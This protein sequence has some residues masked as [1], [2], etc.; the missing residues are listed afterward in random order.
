MEF[1]SELCKAIE[2]SLPVIEE[3][4]A[5][6]SKKF[7]VTIK[8]SRP[9]KYYHLEEYKMNDAD[10]VLV[11]MG[12]VCGTIKEVIDSLRGKGVKVGL[13]KLITYR[14]FPS[15][16]LKKKLSPYKKVAVIE[17]ALSPGGRLPLYVEIAESLYEAD[18]KPQLRSFVVGLGG[19]DVTLGHIEK[20][21]NMTAKGEGKKEEWMF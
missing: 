13:L 10:V 9:E 15:E 19:R 16:L 6:F 3:V 4:M 21:I 18:K 17:K 5:E 8:N 1:R 14:P 12:S 11:A 20:I 7:P 2:G